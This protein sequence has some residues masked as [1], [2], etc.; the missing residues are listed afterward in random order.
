M[1]SMKKNWISSIQNGDISSIVEDVKDFLKQGDAG[2]VAEKLLAVIASTIC[3]KHTEYAGNPADIYKLSSICC[4]SITG[5][6]V[7]NE[8]SYLQCLYHIVNH[9]IVLGDTVSAFSIA[10]FLFLVKKSSIFGSESLSNTC[11]S[12]FWALRNTLNEAAVS[13]ITSATMM[14]RGKLCLNILSCCGSKYLQVF[15]DTSLKIDKL[16]DMYT[17]NN[18]LKENLEFLLNSLKISAEIVKLTKYAQTP[19]LQKYVQL[20]WTILKKDVLQNYTY[21]S[22]VLNSVKIF[23]EQANFENDDKLCLLVLHELAAKAQPLPN[24][25][26]LAL[27][28]FI[29]LLASKHSY[30]LG[31]MVTY[32]ISSMPF[33]FSKLLTAW[34]SWSDQEWQTVWNKTVQCAFYELI[35]KLI[36]VMYELL[37]SEGESVQ[38]ENSIIDSIVNLNRFNVKLVYHMLSHSIDVKLENLDQTIPLVTNILDSSVKWVFYL[39]DSGY[40]NWKQSWEQLAPVFYNTAA[41]LLNAGYHLYSQP[42][43]LNFF[44]TCLRLGSPLQGADLHSGVCAIQNAIKQGDMKEGLRICA[45]CLLN[46]PNDQDKIF[47]FWVQLKC[48]SVNN[49]EIQKY[50]LFHILIE[51]EDSINSEFPGSALNSCDI[52]ELLTA[53]LQY[54]EPYSVKLWSAIESAGLTLYALDPCNINS[55]RGI[56]V[57]LTSI[58][59]QEDTKKIKSALDLGKERI[60][61]L[62][63]AEKESCVQEKVKILGYLG[64]I[65]FSVYILELKSLQKN[66]QKII[67]AQKCTPDEGS[68]DTQGEATDVS[69]AVFTEHL[70]V[71]IEKERELIELLNKALHAWIQLLEH[72]QYI[73]RDL[74]HF[75]KHIFDSIEAASYF[76]GLNGCTVHKVYCW[77]VYYKV[78]ESLEMENAKLYAISSLLKTDCFVAPESWLLEGKIVPFVDSSETC[79]SFQL[80]N[81]WICKSFYHLRHGQYEEGFQ[82]LHKIK[83]QLMHSSTF[84]TEL[85]QLELKFLYSI[86]LSIPEWKIFP[87]FAQVDCISDGVAVFRRIT[88][89]IKRKK[90]DLKIHA[91]LLCML[92]DVACWL[93]D[94][95]LCLYWTSDVYEIL[96]ELLVITQIAGLSTRSAYILT[97]MAEIDVLKSSFDNAKVKLTAL[98]SFFISELWLQ[99]SF[100]KQPVTDSLTIHKLC[101]EMTNMSI[102]NYN[103]QKIID[104]QLDTQTRREIML[105]RTVTIAGGKELSSPVCQHH[106]EKRLSMHPPSSYC[107]CY[108]CNNF[109]SHAVLL[110]YIMVMALFNHFSGNSKTALEFFEDGLSV[111]NALYKIQKCGVQEMNQIKSS[112]LQG[113]KKNNMLPTSFVQKIKTF[114]HHY[115][116]FLSQHKKHEDAKALNQAVASFEGYAN[117]KP[118]C[119]LSFLEHQYALKLLSLGDHPLLDTTV[120]KSCMTDVV[121]DISS[122]KT[123]NRTSAAIQLTPVM[124]YTSKEVDTEFRNNM[125]RLCRNQ[126]KI[127]FD[128]DE[129][130]V[131]QCSLNVKEEKWQMKD[132]ENCD[133]VNIKKKSE[134][135]V[136]KCVKSQN[137]FL[138]VDRNSQSALKGDAVTPLRRQKFKSRQL[139]SQSS[140]EVDNCVSELA[141]LSPLKENLN[142]NIYDN[143]DIESNISSNLSKK[144]NQKLRQTKCIKVSKDV[145]SVA[146]A[147]NSDMHQVI[148][149]TTTKSTAVFK[150]PLHVLSKQKPKSTSK[151]LVALEENSFLTPRRTRQRKISSQS[152]DENESHIS[153]FLLNSPL[154][155]SSNIDHSVTN[156]KQIPKRTT[157]NHRN[158]AIKIFSE[159]SD[160]NSDCKDSK[161]VKNKSKSKR[162]A[163]L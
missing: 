43:F 130:S 48:S 69:A 13:N 40:G 39:K 61:L 100:S 83:D 56:D 60:A 32:T 46:F 52:Q 116:K 121:I 132:Q 117:D 93:V 59:Q 120:Y 122:T 114:I 25:S 87:S 44:K 75:F 9:L 101:D 79:D 72:V 102:T 92:I 20:F 119:I 17:P 103:L 47:K 66:Q 144:P 26:N 129:D 110:H 14:D 15:L 136:T 131:E 33:I 106:H 95:H 127:I 99:H 94:I 85:L 49:M 105:A 148:T 27:K 53:E 77:I 91:R 45:V 41:L 67:S 80:C 82:Q 115:A 19:F 1:E 63:R 81:Y 5:G 152:S 161:V 153:K 113:T 156:K 23:S 140:D 36:S 28:E 88:E 65:C 50:N 51:E 111:C 57:Y 108:S 35:L 135:R 112:I 160:N 154:K 31:N 10:E 42:I 86:Y 71:S 89:H 157:V 74:Q 107:Q 37:H 90:T 142:K 38:N 54:Y 21:F 84:D 18:S 96:R 76:Y 22:D 2:C 118:Y 141:C 124:K 68:R 145:E 134:V 62:T 126:R 4:Q 58:W 150:S 146:T 147:D 7:F 162:K 34:S 29:D 30:K 8:L 3:K 125:R 97:V 70:S 123:P 55:S 11:Y 149:S 104:F 137:I 98:H 138:D 128:L 16:L 158:T 73:T 109:I 163:Q 6:N 155:G 24:V 78:A 159:Y 139:S 151:T 64:D 12:I 143:R 133:I